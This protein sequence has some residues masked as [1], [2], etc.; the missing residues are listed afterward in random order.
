MSVAHSAG[1]SIAYRFVKRTF[2]IVFSG[3]VVAVGLLPSLVLSVVIAAESHGSP[4]Y[5]DHRVGWRGR[6]LGVLK[7]R[8]MVADAD[9]VEKY[10][11]AEQLAEWHR[12]RKVTDDPRVTRVGRLLRATSIDELPQ[13][14]NVLVGQMSVIGPRPISEEELGWFGEDRDLLLSV[15]P[16]I[17]GWWQVAAR[18]D[19]D[20]ESGRRQALELEYVR[21][22][23]LAMD[24]KAFVGTF[25][26]IFKKM[27]R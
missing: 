7:F 15:R 11:S 21:C 9:D 26:A 17:T 2:D 14:L 8:S 25:G 22:A 4:F 16:G 24:W 18:N 13:F 23:G 10:L 20:F 27:G 6:P 12:E 1:G 5:I 3:C 19:A